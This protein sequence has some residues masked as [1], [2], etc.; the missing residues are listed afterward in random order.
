MGKLAELPIKVNEIYSLQSQTTMVTLYDLVPQLSASISPF[1]HFRCMQQFGPH[2]MTSERAARAR[3]PLGAMRLGADP[4]SFHPSLLPSFT[5][6]AC[7]ELR[8]Q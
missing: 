5:R 4:P 1:S 7:D 8:W 3:S 2:Y 6:L